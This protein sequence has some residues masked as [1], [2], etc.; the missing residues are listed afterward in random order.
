MTKPKYY[1]MCQNESCPQKGD[2]LRYV[3]F[4]ENE[5]DSEFIQVLNPAHYPQGNECRHFQSAKKVR[6]AWGMKKTY[7]NISTKNA[8]S[9]KTELKAHFGSTKYYRLCSGEQPIT[10]EIQAYI[11]SIFQKNGETTAPAYDNFTEERRW[12]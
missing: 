1:S 7:E 5:Y 9:I 4:A 12:N 3:A 11:L 8:D 2:C 10:P 6:I